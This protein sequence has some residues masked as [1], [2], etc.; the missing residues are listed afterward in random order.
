LAFFFLGTPREV[1]FLSQE[2]KR[3]AQA[4]V[5]S[6]KTGTDRLK[7]PWDWVQFKDVARD[8]Q[9]YM[10]FFIVIINSLPNGGKSVGLS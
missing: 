7:R 3:I 10:F 9:A 5:V 6:N 8:P 4:R 1:L 2:E